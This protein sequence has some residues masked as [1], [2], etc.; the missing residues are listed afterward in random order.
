[1]H[2]FLSYLK[3]TY[4]LVITTGKR[5]TTKLCDFTNAQFIANHITY[6]IKTNSFKVS[7][8]L[9][10]LICKDQFGGSASEGAFMH[11]HDY[12]EICVMQKF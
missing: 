12:C 9:I 10:N 5:N 3:I 7:S 4:K 2:L 6:Q 1:M 11:L 8:S